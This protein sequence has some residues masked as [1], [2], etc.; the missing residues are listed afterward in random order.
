MKKIIIFLVFSMLALVFF[1]CDFQIPTAIEIEGSPSVR[2]AETVDIG[3]MF[4]DLINKAIKGDGTEGAEGIEHMDIVPCT[5]PDLENVTF[6]IHMDLFDRPLTIEEDAPDLSDFPGFDLDDYYDQLAAGDTITL[7]ED[8]DLINSGEPM[9]VPLSSLG[10]YLIGFKFKNFDTK[11][12][13]SGAAII[14]KFIIKIATVEIDENNTDPIAEP[15]PALYKV[16][17]SPTNQAS[18][19]NE[20][21]QKNGYPETTL[22][23]G[24]QLDLPVNGKDVAVFFKVIVPSGTLINRSDLDDGHIKVEAVVWLPFEFVA[25]N[26]D[27]EIVFPNDTLFSSKDDLFG[28]ESPDA[29]NMM[30]DIVESLSLKIVLNKNIFEDADLVV[31]SNKSDGSDGI[32]ITNK[33]TDN[34][35]PFIISEDDM[36]KI[37]DKDY[38]PFTPNF[39]LKFSG[40]KTLCFPKELK[41]TDI[42]FSAKIKHRIDL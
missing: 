29:E 28:R 38:F 21:W 7:T 5:N 37:N 25:D 11:L 41:A 24:S 32:V 30:T 8:R 39:K 16:I 36:K 20:E 22:I 6:L 26:D 4:T 14:D 17:P 12:Y 42:I 34:F 27:A 33:I 13:F 19:F 40:G 23:G 31:Y 2:F 35:L 15:D 10:S 3:E 1:A 18:G 9:I